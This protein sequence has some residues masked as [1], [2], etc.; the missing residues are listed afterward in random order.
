M[1]RQEVLDI[2]TK[3]W[4]E[5]QDPNDA[6]VSSYEEIGVQLLLKAL[7]KMKP[8]PDKDLVAIVLRANTGRSHITYFR[9]NK[10]DGPRMLGLHHLESLALIYAVRAD[11]L[12]YLHSHYEE[13]SLKLLREM[14][15]KNA[16]EKKIG[17]SAKII[18]EFTTE[19]R[20]SAQVTLTLEEFETLGEFCDLCLYFSL[21]K[22][23][24]KEFRSEFN[25][26]M[27]TLRIFQDSIKEESESIN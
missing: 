19:F 3:N 6:L 22:K 23:L 15:D 16:L 17:E 8:A 14:I 4:S 7:A 5:Q 10:I 2:A 9:S 18:E 21:G 25:E 12:R 11:L 20:Q 27:K 1:T 24:F 13:S 26:T